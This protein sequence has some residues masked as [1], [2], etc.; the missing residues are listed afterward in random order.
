[1]NTDLY[2]ISWAKLA[3]KK[4]ENL[5]NNL[6]VSVKELASLD[7]ECLLHSIVNYEN[8]AIYVT[9]GLSKGFFGGYSTEYSAIRYD[10]AS[11]T[12]SNAPN[13]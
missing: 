13:L 7:K 2:L 5:L 1:M 6:E 12:F 11:N 3:V 8:Q 9:G 4:V 10:L